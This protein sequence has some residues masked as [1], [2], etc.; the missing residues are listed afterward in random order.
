MKSRHRR[1]PRRPGRWVGQL[2]DEQQPV[3]VVGVVVV[4][5]GYGEPSRDRD[6][7]QPAG[8]QLEL[9]LARVRLA[10]DGRMAAVFVDDELAALS[11]LHK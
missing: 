6:G 4:A 1:F 3:I 11:A 8:E 7:G 10:T 5:F 9:E 2:T